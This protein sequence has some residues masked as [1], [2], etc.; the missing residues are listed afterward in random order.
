MQNPMNS[1]QNLLVLFGLRSR[2]PRAHVSKTECANFRLLA[3]LSSGLIFGP[4]SVALAENTP[5]SISIVPSQTMLMN[6]P[7]GNISVTVGDTETSAASLVLSATSSDQSVV[8]NANIILGGAGENRTVTITPAADQ[9]GVTTITVTVTDTGDAMGA[10]VRS[11]NRAFQLTV[12]ALVNG[13]KRELYTGI[14][15]A[16]VSDLTGNPKF[17]NLPD[18]VGVTG[19]LEAPANAGDDYGQRLSGYLRPPVTGSY[20]FYIA[21]DDQSQLFLS[22]D[23]SPANRVLLVAEP[24][25]NG[26]REWITGNNQASRGNPPSNIST[27]VALVAGQLYYLEVLHKEGIFA[28]HVAVAWQKPGDPVPANGDAPIPSQFLVHAESNPVAVHFPDPNLE[29]VIREAVGKSTGPIFQSEVA[30]LQTLNGNGRGINN[31]SGLESAVSLWKL[32]LNN[33]DITNLTPLAGLSQLRELWL[34]RNLISSLAPL[35]GLT[36]MGALFLTQNQASDLT[37]LSGMT[38]LNGLFLSSNQI[39]DLT[40][41]GTL[42]GLRNLHLN[43]NPLA[44]LS[45][46]SALTGLQKLS[47]SFCQIIGVSPLGEITA[48]EELDLSGNQIADLS[49]LSGLPHLW[50]LWMERNQIADL[51][52]LEDLPA[53]SWVSFVRNQ[54]SDLGPLASLQNLAGLFLSNNQ[55]TDLAPLQGLSNL[56]VLH[57]NVN[58]VASLTPLSGLAGMEELKS[59]FTAISDLSPIAGL[60]ALRRIDFQ[61]NSIYDIAVLSGLPLLEEADVRNNLLD[62]TPG[63]AAMTII[64]ALQFDGVTV[65]FTPQRPLPPGLQA[66]PDHAM[67]AGQSAIPVIFTAGDPGRAAHILSVVGIS[68]DQSIVAN[69][70]ISLSGTGPLRTLAFS[71]AAGGVGTATITVTVNYSSGSP[72]SV[73]DTFQ[74]VVLPNGANNFFIEAEDFNFGSGQHQTVTDTMPYLGGAYAGLGATH[75]VDYF[76]TVA[77][78][79]ESDRYR[80][81]EVPNVGIGG[82]TGDLNRGSFNVTV[83]YQIGWNGAGDWYNYTRNFP[84]GAY[85]VYAR[86]AS[87]ASDMHAELGLVTNGTGTLNQSVVS[88]G[89]FDAPATGDWGVFS[90]VPL[91]T[92]AGHPATVHL[93]GERTVRFTVLPGNLDVSYL[94]FVPAATPSGPA[95]ALVS[96]SGANNQVVVQFSQMLD[97]VSAV[98][99]SHYSVPGLIASGAALSADAKTVTLT[100]SGFSGSPA[101]LTV[102][103]V[104][105]ASGVAVPPGSSINGNFQIAVLPNNSNNFFIEAED[106]NFGSGQHQAAADAMPYAGDAYSGLGA[107]HGVDYFQTVADPPESDR[108]RTGEVPNVG[109]GGPTGDLNRGSFNITVNYQ[110][111]W[112]GDGDWYNY[113]RSFPAGAYNVYARLASGGSD[114]H[115]ELGLVTSSAMTVSQTVVQLGRFDA[116]ATGDWNVFTLVPLKTDSGQLA[117]V[118]LS[119]ERTVRFT[120]LQGN[121]DINYLAFVPATAPSGPAPAIV[122]VLEVNNQVWVQFDQMLDPVSATDPARY[123]VTGATVTGVT[124]GADAKQVILAVAGFSGSTVTVIVNGVVGAAGVAVPDGT[125]ANGFVSPLTPVDIPGAGFAAGTLFPQNLQDFDI[126]AGGNTIGGNQD[127]FHYDYQSWSGDFDAIVRVERLDHSDVFAM[128]GLMIRQNLTPGSP[129]VSL[130]VNPTT[131]VNNH[132]ARRRAAPDGPTSSWGGS[133]WTAGTDP[134]LRLKRLGDVLLAYRSPNGA[135]WTKIGQITQGFS[136]PVLLGLATSPGNPGV[137]TVANYR[138][139]AVSDTPTPVLQVQAADASASEAGADTGLFRISALPIQTLPLTV[140][141]SV[142]GTAQPGVDYESL[143]GSVTIP[144]GQNSASILVKPIVNAEVD[145]YRTVTLTVAPLPGF[146]MESTAATVGLFDD[147]S[148]LGFL[149]REI[150]SELSGDVAGSELTGAARFPNAP[151]QADVIT[152]FESPTPAEVTLGDNYGTR[153]S[154]YVIPPETGSYTF[155]ISADDHAQLWLSTSDN[156]AHKALIAFEPLF[157]FPRNWVGTERRNPVNPENRSAPILLQAG[158]P[159]FI[160][161]LHKEGG[162][163]DNVAVAWQKPGD[164]VPVNGSDPIGSAFLAL[165]VPVSISS[166]NPA[167]VVSGG[168]DFVLTVNG[169]GFANGDKVF[170]NASG[171]ET[172]RQTTFV[173]SRQL[174]ALITAS[175][176]ASSTE[177]KTATVT[178]LTPGG[179]ESNPAV[180]TVGSAAVAVVESIVAPPGGSVA[181]STAPTSAPAPGEPVAGVSA[182]YHNTSTDSSV[183]VTAATYSTNPNAGTLF[184]TGGGFVDLQVTGASPSDSMAASFYYPETITGAIEA[185]LVLLYFDGS[186]WLPVFSSGG[187]G[188]AK[189]TTDHLDGTVSGGRF[190]VVFDNTST[191]RIDQLDGTIFASTTREAAEDIVG[192]VP[193]TE[194][195]PMLVGECSVNVPI[196]TATD[197]VTGP[198][199]GETSNPLIYAIPGNYTV[200]WT[201]TDGN[202]NQTTQSQTVMVLPMAFEGFFAPLGGTDASGGSFDDPLKTFKLGSTIPVKFKASCGG[203]PVLIGTHTLE[204]K[205]FS[206]QTDSEDAILVSATDAATTG[207]QFRLSDGEWHFNL[208]TKSL[209][210]TAGKYQLTATLSDGSKHTAWVQLK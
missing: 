8:P 160:E 204:I 169:A 154:G 53:L 123:T 153:L 47:A 165:Y 26:S 187:V 40:G 185:S 88:L 23:M 4:A 136:D 60:T 131:G 174:T 74:V 55:I 45:P 196:P 115:A 50:F 119:E 191:P 124:L 134:W 122:S 10:D 157:N 209:N 194:D 65:Q 199:A 95:P 106:F 162:G 31:L 27:T 5:P 125:S 32:E 188:P 79:P 148:I 183:S 109:I 182:T 149:K 69:G 89:R 61:Q 58:P 99:I 90:F 121:L 91:K 16:S 108:Y 139:Y 129:E 155:F 42:G 171:T 33:N 190:S 167:A 54:I 86:L 184:D 146:E 103:G 189:D 142:G 87:G 73:S 117:T 46:L 81:G 164:L 80:N 114:M 176:I 49:G 159:Y 207:N 44:S 197:A 51:S 56:R 102:N 76:Q 38:Q 112:N 83:N 1:I 140:D 30:G 198:V 97:P 203:A 120:V 59:S 110:I 130:V 84:P 75:G 158:Q 143:P 161:A 92:D 22:T 107:T 71:S 173:N 13:L 48:L 98:D 100:V 101:T 67:F 118:H 62:L 36:Q 141:Y 34:E 147:H 9:F 156:P 163:A 116:P 20:V 152:A 25:W 172:E 105:G 96:L 168:G 206:I 133:V 6:V 17:P 178:V 14:S 127:A 181:V 192:S 150:Y 21:S 72:A 179:Q 151:H 77:D 43:A 166:L 205:Q 180:F 145:G 195:L 93:N 177:I 126:V 128:A 113:T 11:S 15:G 66:L 104:L 68:S 12:M 210:L 193:D 24:Q 18:S 70:S 82:P 63:L 52:A 186:D 111:G 208:G 175:D 37:P 29:A 19:S 35:S 39:S 144:S 2:C 201:Y 28:D 78:P 85:N 41:L 137:T 64:E 135:T 7:I 3:L 202:G 200:V 94:A 170:W 132:N 138:G 57:L